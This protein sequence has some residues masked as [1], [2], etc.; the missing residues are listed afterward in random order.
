MYCSQASGARRGADSRIEGMVRDNA[1]SGPVLA[2]STVPTP[3]ELA[4]EGRAAV[5]IDNASIFL[6]RAVFVNNESPV[7]GLVHAAA[8]GAPRAFLLDCTF[9]RNDLPDGEPF[10]TRRG[11]TAQILAD[12]ELQVRRTRTLDAPHTSVLYR[13]NV[14]FLKGSVTAR[15]RE[16]HLVL[17]FAWLVAAC[18]PA[19][20][21]AFVLVVL[22]AAAPGVQVLDLATGFTAPSAPAPTNPAVGFITIQDSFLAANIPSSRAVAAAEIEI[23]NAPPTLREDLIA[24][25]QFLED[26]ARNGPRAAVIGVIVALALTFVL[27]CTCLVCVCCCRRRRTSKAVD[28][29]M[30][31]EERAAEYA[32]GIEAAD[33]SMVRCRPLT[34]CVV[35]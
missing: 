23:Q 14:L 1:T 33:P 10:V 16:E 5:V 32:A 20:C 3:A 11:V 22:T 24:A 30:T 13:P 6:N 26:E 29:S 17:P 21:T 28:E 2:A 7:P 9:S 35:G 12:P 8:A 19:H 25:E 31:A 18:V 27:C 15:A 34:S 4:H